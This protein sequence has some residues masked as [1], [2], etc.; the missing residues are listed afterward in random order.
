MISPHLAHE[1][2][3]PMCRKPPTMLS[4]LIKCDSV[5]VVA[6][7]KKE[8][9]DE[10]AMKKNMTSNNRNGQTSTTDLPTGSS[11][12]APLTL[13]LV[14]GLEPPIKC[15][16]IDGMQQNLSVVASKSWTPVHQHNFS[17]DLCDLFVSCGITWNS[18]SNPQLALFYKK[19]IPEAEI[20]DQRVLVVHILKEQVAD[21]EGQTKQK[22]KGNMA[23]ASVTA[24]RMS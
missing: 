6:D 21:V 17:C 3:D 19:C 13:N 22:V 16:R 14:A 4:H 2:I 18:T 9:E 1:N 11:G 8:V 12:A 5:A 10:K 15:H 7:V 20:P 24:G 23:W